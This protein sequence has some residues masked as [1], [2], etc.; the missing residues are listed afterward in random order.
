M[1]CK[2]RPLPG[3]RRLVGSDPRLLPA[4]SRRPG[5]RR[6]AVRTRAAGSLPASG[7]QGQTVV[8]PRAGRQG[9]LVADGGIAAVCSDTTQGF[10][11]GLVGCRSPAELGRGRELTS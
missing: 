9:G 2:L 1:R 10:S 8:R 5:L 6:T 11:L 7:R 4:L 3:L